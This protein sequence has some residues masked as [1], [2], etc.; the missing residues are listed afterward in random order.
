MIDW[1]K[2]MAKRI[3]NMELRYSS[4]WI[5]LITLLFQ[6][7]RTKLKVVK[8]LWHFLGFVSWHRENHAHHHHAHHPHQGLVQQLERR[9]RYE[10]FLAHINRYF[11]SRFSKFQ[12]SI[13]EEPSKTGIKPRLQKDEAIELK[14]LVRFIAQFYADYPCYGPG[15]EMLRVKMIQSLFLQFATSVDDDRVDCLFILLVISMDKIGVVLDD[16]N[17]RKKVVTFSNMTTLSP[18]RKSMMKDLI[19]LY[20]RM[21]NFGLGQFTGGDFSTF[22][23]EV[24]EEENVFEQHRLLQEKLNDLEKMNPKILKKKI[25][26]KQKK[27]FRLYTGG[28]VMVFE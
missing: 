9:F 16:K 17:N 27:K 13:F 20:L 3:T 22:F 23:S 28:S 4:Q 5:V 10:G 21:T 24:I 2:E 18:E 19:R 7:G 25:E 12:I 6:I 26:D 1:V 11:R 14:Q 15:G 8:H